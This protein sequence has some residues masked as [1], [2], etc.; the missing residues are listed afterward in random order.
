M[1]SFQE[2]YVRS[3]ESEN[4]QLQSVSQIKPF[5][6]SEDVNSQKKQSVKRKLL[7]DNSDH[8]TRTNEESNQGYQK[9]MSTNMSKT[10]IKRK[11]KEQDF[12]PFY[13]LSEIFLR[14]VYPLSEFANKHVTVGFCKFL[15][16]TP[17]IIINHG[18]KQVTF[19]EDSWR[20]FGRSL[21]VIHCYLINKV[22]GKKTNI[23]IENCDL[24]LSM[25][26]VRGELFAQIRNL[27]SHDEKL[28]LN[29]NEL[30][31]LINTSPAIDRY[32]QQL[33]VC[34]TI[35]KDY[36]I[37]TIENGEDTPLLYTPVD[38][39]IYNRLPQEVYLFRTLKCIQSYQ[40]EIPIEETNH[41]F[42][43]DQPL[44]KF[45]CEVMDEPLDLKNTQG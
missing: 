33:E 31:M 21:S 14:I 11:K 6:G 39:L 15:D 28:L 17:G 30:E 20:S 45:K 44:I 23:G 7:N 27:S 29:R 42:P 8:I 2:I 32:I 10:L 22:Y 35:I 9:E 13:M 34:K 37:N 16:Y 43:E 4:L 12:L 3:E 41:D 36:L 24:E 26:K 1:E 5:Q 19:V 18:G 25:V 40:N 38:S